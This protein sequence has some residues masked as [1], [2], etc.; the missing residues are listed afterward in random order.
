MWTAA[1]WA[2]FNNHPDIIFELKGAGAN[3]SA[4]DSFNASPLHFAVMRGNEAAIRALCDAGLSF[5]L[6]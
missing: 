5:S 2:A 1:H 4:V 6:F 3:I